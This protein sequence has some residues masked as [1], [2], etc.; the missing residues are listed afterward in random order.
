MCI[1]IEPMVNMGSE[2]IF[3]K[4]DGWTICTSDGKPSAHFE[5]TLAVGL[6]S[7]IILTNGIYD[8]SKILAEA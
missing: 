4:E 6:E 2:H 5:H 3:T 1:A 7:G 8:T